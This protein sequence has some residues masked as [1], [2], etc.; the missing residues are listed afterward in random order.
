MS[1]HTLEVAEQVCDQIGIIHKGKLIAQDTPD[2]LRHSAG[3]DSS[4][5]EAFIHLTGGRELMDM[6]SAL[7]EE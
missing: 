5:E 7:K 3:N 6:V 2:N 4:L 1:T